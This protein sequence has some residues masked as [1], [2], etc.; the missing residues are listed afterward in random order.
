MTNHHYRSLAE[1]D[2]E[3]Y[4]AIQNETRRQHEGLELIASENFVSEAVLTAAGSVFTNKYAEGY[5]GKRYYGGCEFTDVVESLAIS[6]AKQ[7]FGA[8]HVNVQPHSGSQANMAVYLTACQ[9]GDTVLGMDLSHGGHLTHG[10]P[11]N[12][13][14]KSY[15]VVA[16]GVKKDDETI[17]YDQMEALANEHK[18]KLIVCGASAYSRV[19]DFERIAAIAHG[20]GALVMADIAHIAGL[21]VAGLHPSPVP[22]CDFVTTTTHKTLRGPRAGMIMCKEQFAKDLDRNIFPGIQGGPLVH[23]IAAKAVAF[24]EALQPEFKAYQQQ[25]VKNAKALAEAVAETGFR[26]VSGGTDNHV[27]L[28][29]VFSKG[30]LGKDAEKALE[31]AHITVNKNTIPFDTNPPMKASGVRL[32]SPAVTTRGLGEA[33][34]KQIAGLIAE[35]LLAPTDETVRQNVIGKVKELTARFPLY[36]NR[37]PQTGASAGAD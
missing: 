6:R 4:A 1:S 33:E 11:L 22:H 31:A 37:L 17:D 28:V 32:G 24:K 35:V 16:Y 20:V 10:H 23:I 26:I 13:S 12:F 27:F 15:K 25:V 8:E 18:P 14:G 29:D 34:M 2:P 30:I 9:H 7:M 19:I 36:A 3:I 5:P 21:V